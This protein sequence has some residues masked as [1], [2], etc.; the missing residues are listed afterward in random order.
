MIADE[1]SNNVCVVRYVI[2]G[3]Q[4]MREVIAG[5]G[6]DTSKPANEAL[7]DMPIA[8]VRRKVNEYNL[9]SGVRYASNAILY[10]YV[11]EPVP[12]QKP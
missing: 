9:K 4:R 12:P 1:Y 10:L 11:I 3:D 7:E 6:R 2:N 5:K 8:W